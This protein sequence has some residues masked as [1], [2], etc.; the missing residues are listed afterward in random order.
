MIAA[1]A[2]AVNSAA[3]RW[4]ARAGRAGGRERATA[5]TEL[6]A[7]RRVTCHTHHV[8]SC[9]VYIEGSVVY[10]RW[11]AKHLIDLDEGALESAQAELGTATIRDTVNTALRLAGATRPISVAAALDVLAKAELDDRSEAW[12]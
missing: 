1:A 12:R 8:I 9:S 6:C 5:V 7:S 4:R 11:V 2:S 3:R 10:I